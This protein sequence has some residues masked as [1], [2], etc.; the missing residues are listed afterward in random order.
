MNTIRGEHQPSP[1]QQLRDDICI[2]IFTV[3]ATLVGVCLTV[4]GVLRIVKRLQGVAIL[5][6]Q[7]L[8]VNAIGFLAACAVAYAALRAEGVQRRRRLE[9]SADIVFLCSL[10]MMTIVCVLIAREFV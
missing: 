8:S 5:A 3:S 9:R 1:T 10:A 6:D 7:V 4:I 2:H